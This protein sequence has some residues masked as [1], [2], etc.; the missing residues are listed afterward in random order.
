M[1]SLEARF[2]T[3]SWY[4]KS[5]NQYQWE[6]F[7]NRPSLFGDASL[8]GTS[9]VAYTVIKQ[10]SS[11]KQSFISSLSHLSK[12]ST[13]ISRLYLVAI[14]MV[15]NLAET[16]WNSLTNFKIT[17]VH[18]WSNNMVVLHWIKGNNIHKQFVQNRINHINSK[19]PIIWHCFSTY[20]NPAD[21]VSRGCN[22]SKLSKILLEGPAWLKNWKDWPEH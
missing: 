12:K 3:F 14:A 9:A 6:T 2:T 15:V 22:V 18:D 4:N 10:C 21:I 1:E 11:I 5:Y 20:K 13:S 7:R 19:P 17:A 8:I 16:I